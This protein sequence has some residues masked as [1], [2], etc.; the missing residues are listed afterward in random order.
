[1]VNM[2]RDRLRKVGDRV[3][4]GRGNLSYIICQ[5]SVRAH[6]THVRRFPMR[7]CGVIEMSAG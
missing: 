3:I 1:M 6:M 4:Y 5:K 7:L 2:V